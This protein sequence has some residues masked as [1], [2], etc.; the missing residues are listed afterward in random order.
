MDETI[1]KKEILE[2]IE[3][4]LLKGNENVIEFSNKLK[5][6]IL[7]KVSITDLMKLIESTLKEKKIYFLRHAQAEHNVKKGLNSIRIYD[8]SLT[9]EGKNQTEKIL[10]LLKELDISF[11][12]IFISPLKRALQTFYCIEKYFTNKNDKVE[13]ICT[14]LIREALTNK[15][16]N[17]GMN[18]QK[19]KEYI[20]SNNINMNLNFITKDFWWIDSGKFVENPEPELRKLFKIRIRIFLLWIIFRFEKNILLISHSKVNR[21][22]NNKEKVKN[23]EIIELKYENIFNNCVK[24]FKKEL[25]FNGDKNINKNI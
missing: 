25:E 23:S 1:I 14:D 21:L 16:K 20:D 6:K 18:L 4:F 17:K 7:S 8:S 10:L 5:N 11:D 2:I 9:E 3:S 24:Y 15:D 19:L 13:Y 12:L 22:L